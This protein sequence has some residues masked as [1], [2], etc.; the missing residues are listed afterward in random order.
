MNMH[1][2]VDRLTA[3]LGGA[4]AGRNRFFARKLE[5]PPLAHAISLTRVQAPEP[6]GEGIY[7]TRADTP[8][9]ALD[10]SLR[11]ARWVGP[12]RPSL[13]Y[14]Q[15]SGERPFDFSARSKNTFRTVVLEAEEDWR[16]NLCVLRAPF[17]SGTQRDYAR[18]MGDLANFTGMLA[19]L[20]V[21]VE[22]LVTMLR[23]AGSGPVVVSGISLGGWAV[24]LHAGC[25]G[26]ADRYL[27][28]LA[29]AALDDLFLR[30]RYRCLTAAPA[31]EQPGLM[32]E[33][34]NFEDSF[35]DAPAD[36]VFP[37]LG[38]HDQFIRHDP[39]VRSYGKV[40]VETIERGHVT[41]AASPAL[42]RHHIRRHM[43]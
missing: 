19:S 31:L 36:R 26:T 29:G 8:A 13:I 35:R 14:L 39:Q 5:S 28:L 32:E 43:P 37:L 2:L 16:A 25:F 38:R 6:E 18:S 27:P 42:L 15:G 40:R 23:K 22:E 11:I 34:L 24:N 17:H 33:V 12:D 9:G 1:A 3:G 21:L 41:A 20:V 7:E 4:F 30:S 10:P